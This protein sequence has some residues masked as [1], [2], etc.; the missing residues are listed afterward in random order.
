MISCYIISMFFQVLFQNPL[1]WFFYVINTQ[2]LNKIP[3]LSQPSSLFQSWTVIHLKSNLRNKTES[4]KVEKSKAKILTSVYFYAEM[5]AKIR[6]T[7]NGSFHVQ[8]S[9]GQI[10]IYDRFHTALPYWKKG[11]EKCLQFTN[12]FLSNKKKN[13]LQITQWRPGFPIIKKDKRNNVYC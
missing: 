9:T 2:G 5:Q 3:L 12:F 7:N 13:N 1:V 8:K 4:R 6:T 10:R 11:I